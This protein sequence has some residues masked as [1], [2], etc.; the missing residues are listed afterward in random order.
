MKTYCI[1]SDWAD[2]IQ[3]NFNNFFLEKFQVFIIA[4]HEQLSVASWPI[5]IYEAN[6]VLLTK[7]ETGFIAAIMA[8]LRDALI[9]IEMG[10]FLVGTMVKKEQ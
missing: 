10:N 2:V 3:H 8:D 6:W 1:N 5:E 9:L 7:S 4:L